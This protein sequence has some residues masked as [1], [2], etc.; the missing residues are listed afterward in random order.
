VFAT[1]GFSLKSG[2]ALG[3][4]VFL[5]IMAGFFHYDTQL[6][7]AANAV[8]GYHASSSIVVGLLFLGGALS[9]AACPLNKARTLQMADALAARRTKA[10][11]PA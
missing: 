3:S 9:I 5:W 11:V 8:A 6:P 1:I 2:L 4:A 7:A 10:G